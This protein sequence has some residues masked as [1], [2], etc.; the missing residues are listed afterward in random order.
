MKKNILLLC[1]AVALAAAGCSFYPAVEGSGFP[2]TTTYNS[3]GF[4]KLAV[5][6]PFKVRI[7]PDAAFSVAVTCDD[8]IVPY[9]IVEKGTDTLRVSLL[10]GYNYRNVILA[11][12]VHMPALAGVSLS[13]AAEARMD[14]GFASAA[15]LSVTLSGA[16]AVDIAALSCGAFSADISGASTFSAQSFSS[17]SLS[18]VVSGGSTISASG[19]TAGETLAVSGASTVHFQSLTGTHAGVNLS[20]AS[21]AYINVGNGP[22]TLTASGLSTLYYT[23][24]PTFTINELSGGS[25]ILRL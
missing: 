11:A 9:L 3:I 7:V 15:P 18:A 14:G 4:T 12:E 2:K 16:S 25:T 5:Q 24:N 10:D 13:G 8:N 1:A 20:G 22:I 23:G 17:S 19:T 6:Y 21:R